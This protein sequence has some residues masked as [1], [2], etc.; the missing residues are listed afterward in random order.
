MKLLKVLLKNKTT[1]YLEVKIK[2][3]KRYICDNFD[4]S[5]E[6]CAPGYYATDIEGLTYAFRHA[7]GDRVFE[8]KVSGK[9]KEFD[10]YKRR[11]KIFELGNELTH[12]EVRKMALAHEPICGY[13]L[14]EVL[15]PVNP[16]LLPKAT[17]TDADIELLRQY[18]P[19]MYSVTAS[20]RDSVTA[21][22]RGS[23]W[24][25]VWTSVWDSVRDSV[26]ASVRGSAWTSVW[27]S[28]RE[29][30]MASVMAYCG[31]LFPNVEKWK[32]ID[33]EP[34]VYPF[35]PV[36]DLWYRGL[37]PSYDGKIWRLHSGIN[38]DIVWQGKKERIKK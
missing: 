2:Q 3:G 30:V 14:S 4:T 17:V 31:S 36:V 25:S 20:V 34:G 16:L 38:A 18:S 9:R 8:C 37:I 10:I 32:Y 23:A 26:T 29:S 15:Y 24:D 35:Q 1:P 33:H 28:V 6:E 21:S 27:K 22:V 19:V 13:K 5:D 12:D 7:R 11:Y